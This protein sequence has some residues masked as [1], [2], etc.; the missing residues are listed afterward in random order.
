MKCHLLGWFGLSE[1]LTRALFM[2][3][4]F[5]LNISILSP[6]PETKNSEMA[7]SCL[8]RIMNSFSNPM[9]KV[10]C[11][12]LISAQASLINLNHWCQRYDPIMYVIYNSF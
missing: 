3:V 7:I 10:Y 11:Q 2:L 9:F 6:D 8:S 4:V 5:S 12:F 1:C